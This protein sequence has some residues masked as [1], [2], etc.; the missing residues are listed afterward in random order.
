MMRGLLGLVAIVMALT[1]SAK[2]TEAVVLLVSSDTAGTSS[3][4]R[5]TSYDGITGQFIDTRFGPIDNSINS[6]A[7]GPNGTVYVGEVNNRANTGRVLRID[8]RTGELIDVLIPS[9]NT[10]A[11]MRIGPDGN[12]YVLRS[13]RNPQ[14]Q[15]YD[16]QTGDF[17]DNFASQ[18]LVVPQSLAFGPDGNLYV[19]SNIILSDGSRQS[20]VSR[21]DGASGIFLGSFQTA[22][23]IV[24][25]ELEFGPDGN[26][27]V[28]GPFDDNIARY[29]PIT[30]EFIDEFISSGLSF[31][32]S[33]EFGPDGNLYVSARN[34]SPGGTIG[35]IQRFDGTTGEFIDE[36]VTPGSGGFG[37]PRPGFFFT[38]LSDPTTLPEPTTLTVLGLGLFGLAIALRRQR[39]HQANRSWL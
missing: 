4:G 11:A 38:S 25:T 7:P 14:I 34:P 22:A 35:S 1:V 33:L 31:P 32:D 23:S 37:F 5:I 3:I 8:G 21:F 39:R 2:H 10:P 36:F 30:G 6:M 28:A 20:F 26:L 29:N 19:P 9:L 15:R 17:I 16:A 12:L 27:Y 18:S 24:A 13:G